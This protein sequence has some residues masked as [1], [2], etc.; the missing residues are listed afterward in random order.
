MYQKRISASPVP[1][2]GIMFYV[3]LNISH[4]SPSN[5][6]H[7]CGGQTFRAPL[8]ANDKNIFG[9]GFQ[10]KYLA[11]HSPGGEHGIQ[12]QGRKGVV[13]VPRGY[14]NKF[15]KIVKPDPGHKGRA[16]YIIL[17]QIRTVDRERLVRK[18]GK[19]SPSTLRRT[20]SI[21]QEMFAP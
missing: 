13:S 3:E 17:D 15:V 5:K 10:K 18:L 8:E 4:G 12:P 20:L 21:L 14:H 19:L 16:G 11:R 9:L 2:S 1:S 7:E 6:K